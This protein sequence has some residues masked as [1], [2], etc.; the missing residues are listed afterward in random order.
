M[1]WKDKA[2]NIKLVKISLDKYRKC[3]IYAII[4]TVSSKQPI[5]HLDCSK[6]ITF[7]TSNYLNKFENDKWLV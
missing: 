7:L 6:Y 4:S 2:A 3:I 1:H 5:E